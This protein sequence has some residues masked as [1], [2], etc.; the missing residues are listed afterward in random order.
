MTEELPK[1]LNQHTFLCRGPPG[2]LRW[3]FDSLMRPGKLLNKG[4][5]K[6]HVA[7]IKATWTSH[8]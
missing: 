3:G 6:A 8:L 7:I 1:H 5:K 2:S 4:T